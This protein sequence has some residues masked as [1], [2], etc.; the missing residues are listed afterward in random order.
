MVSR[1]GIAGAVDI[2]CRNTT[3]GGAA[4]SGPRGGVLLPARSLWALL[5]TDDELRVSLLPVMRGLSSCDVRLD[6][7]PGVLNALY[8]VRL[9][10]DPRF[11]L[12][13]DRPGE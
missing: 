12:N 10:T 9:Y 3:G 7:V 5:E 11:F 6:S 4:G 1:S 13:T 8:S 2:G